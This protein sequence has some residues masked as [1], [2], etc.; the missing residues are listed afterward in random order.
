MSKYLIYLNII[1]IVICVFL[2][3]VSSYVAWEYYLQDDIT[4]A[5]LYGFLAITFICD[6]F[7][8]LSTN[9]ALKNLSKE[10]S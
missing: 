1:F 6:I 9:K 7:V 5:V 4:R 3:P 8:F 2:V 10:E